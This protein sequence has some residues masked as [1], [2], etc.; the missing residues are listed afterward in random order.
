MKQHDCIVDVYKDN[1]YVYIYKIIGNGG[2]LNILCKKEWDSYNW[3]GK[4]H[5]RDDQVK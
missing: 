2:Y 4:I 1:Y 3:S 5:P